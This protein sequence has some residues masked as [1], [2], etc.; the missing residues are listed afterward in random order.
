MVPPPISIWDPNFNPPVDPIL[1]SDVQP[2]FD[3]R[4][5]WLNSWDAKDPLAGALISTTSISTADPRAR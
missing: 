1:T 2:Y 5:T 4:T 3:E